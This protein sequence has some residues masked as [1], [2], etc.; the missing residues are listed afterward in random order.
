[1]TELTPDMQ[2]ALKDYPVG[3]TFTVF[4]ATPEP[5]L[6]DLLAQSDFGFDTA[7][8]DE[9]PVEEVADPIETELFSTTVTFAGETVEI[10]EPTL[11][12]ITKFIQFLGRTLVQSQKRIGTEFKG[13]F[14]SVRNGTSVQDVPWQVTLG[15][16]AEQLGPAWLLQLGALAVWG[17]SDE[18]QKRAQEVLRHAPQKDLKIAPIIEALMIRYI[19]S[20]DLREALKNLQKAGRLL[21]TTS[22]KNPTVTAKAPLPT[23]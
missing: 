2:E 3:Q 16:I 14:V 1:M 5:T 4:E 20:D 17:G 21:N 9:A 7:E 13:L 6:G 15:V 18:G 10:E 22:P 8:P 11:T 23:T 12:D 19:L